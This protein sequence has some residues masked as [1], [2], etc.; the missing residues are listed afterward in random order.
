M[1]TTNELTGYMNADVNELF[2]LG[3]IGISAGTHVT[4]GSE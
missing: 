1:R 4:K 3:L 2:W